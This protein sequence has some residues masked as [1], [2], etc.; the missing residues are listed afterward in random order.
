V[1]PDP[2]PTFHVA[3]R[4]VDLGA[5]E[6]GFSLPFFATLLDYRSF[7]LT[8]LS[9]MDLGLVLLTLLLS[10]METRPL[11]L[12]E[13]TLA[14]LSLLSSFMMMLWGALG[15]LRGI[16]WSDYEFLAGPSARVTG[17]W[18]SGALALA[19]T[20]SAG[21]LIASVWGR[22]KTPVQGTS[23]TWYWT[24]FQTVVLVLGLSTGSLYHGQWNPFALTLGAVVFV[25]S[26]VLLRSLLV[27]M[28]AT[29]ENPK[30]GRG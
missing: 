7:Y 26:L 14:G 16:N 6:T 18:I 3:S 9:L 1:V 25:A 11:S 28:M 2:N 10:V 20:L 15:P 5:G 4:Y 22:N 30:G 29:A 13:R 12:F 21:V 23:K 19:A 8:L 27:L 24:G 17:G